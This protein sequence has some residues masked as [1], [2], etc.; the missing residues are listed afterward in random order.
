MHP[1]AKG[2]GALGHGLGNVPK[3]QQTQG[4]CAQLGAQGPLATSP[5]SPALL[6]QILVGACKR[7]MA[8]EQCRD[9][10]F[11]DGVFMAKTVRQCALRG[12]QRSVDGICACSRGMEQLGIHGA[13]HAVAQFDADHHV[14]AF[15]MRL[16]LRLVQ[17]VREVE[18]LVY[19]VDELLKA[20]AKVGRILAVK[21]NFQRRG[22][23]VV[24]QAW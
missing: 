6:A 22:V 19:G 20:R 7:Q 11:R 9:H 12:Q 16:F 17:G 14:G 18:D 23:H 8:H 3:T 4:L 15:V 1:H 2:L 5:V 24:Q 13:G 10:V 21:N